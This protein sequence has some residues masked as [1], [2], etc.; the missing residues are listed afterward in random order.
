MSHDGLHA[1]SEAFFVRIRAKFCK[2]F[3][4]YVMK[5]TK[6]KDIDTVFCVLV[7][8]L[9]IKKKNLEKLHFLGTH[10]FVYT[11]KSWIFSPTVA[12]IRFC[13][14][15]VCVSE[16]EG[17][18]L[19]FIYMWCRVLSFGRHPNVRLD[20]VYRHI[21]HCFTSHLGSGCISR[22]WLREHLVSSAPMTTDLQIYFER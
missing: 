11:W 7:A 5:M 9:I 4:F 13:V 22:P 10:Q 2:I 12:E 16:P 14:N 1:I 17:V 19:S 3:T 20:I 21:S 6:Y 18:C 8:A 15:L